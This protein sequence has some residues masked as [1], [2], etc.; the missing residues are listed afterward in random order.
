MNP[1][2][3]GCLPIVQHDNQ[4]VHNTPVLDNTATSLVNDSCLQETSSGSVGINND[5]LAA[6]PPSASAQPN[7]NP[8]QS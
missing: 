8:P 1:K 5:A 2:A 4:L 6:T 3:L 7:M